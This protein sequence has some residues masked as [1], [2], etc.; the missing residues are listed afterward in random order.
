[1]ILQIL[2]TTDLRPSIL[3]CE[4][5]EIGGVGS[6]KFCQSPYIDDLKELKFFIELDR[7][8]ANDA[9]FYDCGNKKFKNFIIE[10]TE[11]ETAIGS[12]SD[13]SHLSPATDVASVNLSCG[14]YNAHTLEEKVIFE[15]MMD[16]V[17]VIEDLIYAARNQNKFDYQEERKGWLYNDDDWFGFRK[18]TYSNELVGLEIEFFDT[19]KEKAERCYDFIWGESYLECLGQFFMDNPLICMDDIIDITEEYEDDYYY[20]NQGYGYVSAY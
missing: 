15:E 4:D 5:E 9:V 14:Y 16:T 1:M 10:T 7:A 6:S 2:E 8:N 11:Y 13:I 3:F 17:F 18:G 20:K 19:S 12:F